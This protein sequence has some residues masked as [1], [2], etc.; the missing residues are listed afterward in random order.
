MCMQCCAESYS[1]DD[2]FLPGWSLQRARKDSGA[3]TG[4]GKEWKTRQLAL[5][6]C[7]DPDFIFTV[8]P[9]KDPYFYDDDPEGVFDGE[10]LDVSLD[11][12][13]DLRGDPEPCYHLYRAALEAGYN[14]EVPFSSWL[15]QR[16]AEAVEKA[17]LGGNHDQG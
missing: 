11:I 8:E 10:M 16:M 2:D 9:I 12:C 4:F 7:N 15:M 14:E 6:R 17:D 1:I 3:T 5:V 13:E